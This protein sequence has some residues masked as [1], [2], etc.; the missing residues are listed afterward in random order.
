MDMGDIKNAAEHQVLGFLLSAIHDVAAQLN[1][2]ILALGQLNR[3]AL[4]VDNEAT[5]TGSDKITH[6]VDSLTLMR[7]KRQ[8]ELDSDGEMRGNYLFKTVLA[9]SGAGHDWNEWINIHFEKSAGQF[10][11]D[12]R[13]SEVVEALQGNKAVSDRIEDMDTGP[14]GELRED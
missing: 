7:A 8:E 3:E 9:R 14:F 11:E 4:K 6:N 13:N 2:P 5:V 1:I 12:K 10:K